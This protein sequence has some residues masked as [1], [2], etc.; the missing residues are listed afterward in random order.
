[1]AELLHW[2]WAIVRHLEKDGATE[3]GDAGQ[4]SGDA[5]V[6]KSWDIGGCVAA[7]CVRSKYLQEMSKPLFLRFVSKIAMHC[8]RFKIEVS[9]IVERDRIQAKIGS[10]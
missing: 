2:S 1:M 10:L 7:R 8:D 4:S 3:G 6:H 9:V 5:V